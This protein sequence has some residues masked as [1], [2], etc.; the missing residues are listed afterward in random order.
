MDFDTVVPGMY[1]K[2]MEVQ[3]SMCDYSGKLGV[4]RTFELFMDLAAEHANLI[5][6][7]QPY[8]V[9][10]NKFWLTVKTRIRFYDRPSMM[11]RLIASTWPVK[12]TSFRTDRCYRLESIEAGEKHGDRHGERHGE[13]RIVAE[14]CTEWAVMNLE[15]NTLERLNDLFP[16]GFEFCPDKLQFTGFP[17][18]SPSFD[19]CT[20]RGRTVVLSSDVDLGNHMNNA[21]YV[22]AIL[23]NYSTK[24]LGDMDIREMSIAFK[25][26]AHEGD[27]L[28]M[29]ER[30]VQHEDKG[31]SIEVA[32][33]FKNG[34]T[35]ALAQIEC[36]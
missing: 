32:L 31:K 16:C 4:Y 7:G 18:I 19:D 35:A 26:P 23:G 3:P 27:E 17:R 14:G 9:A 12:P 5:G 33:L 29:V 2:A 10:N 34:E 11:E 21:C 25:A 6:I 20:E 36:G 15:T 30:V 22:R 1:S 13:R 8:M 28:S 24:Q